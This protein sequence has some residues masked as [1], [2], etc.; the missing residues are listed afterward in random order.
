MSAP[1]ISICIC[2]CRRPA[3]LEQLLAALALQCA[4]DA[5]I[6]VADNDP[7]HS[8]QAVLERWQQRLP[9]R[10]V[11][12]SQPNIALARN[13]TI[14]LAKGHWI[15]LI[16]D[17]ELPSPTWLNDLL[18]TQRRFAA[19]IVMAP[20]LPGYGPEIPAWLREGG[21]FERPRHTT[22]TTITDKDAR[23]GNA[24]IRASLLKAIQ[25]PFDPD[26]G[27]SGGEDSVIFRQLYRSGAQFV[28]CDEAIVTEPVAPDRARPGWL[29]RRAYRFG[30]TTIQVE[31]YRQTLPRQLLIGGY[32][33]AR[34]L[35]QCAIALALS[36]F[37]AP[38]SKIKS[39]RWL[40][41]AVAQLGKLSAL[42]GRRYLEYG[43]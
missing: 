37:N 35:L 8:A 18:D 14:E 13:A 1:G 5:E 32:L 27:R 34:A 21:F 9:L 19:D 41:T 31:L 3:M 16:D 12:V 7:E 4:G 10:F 11:H 42:L 36:I 25:G 30:Q 29:L 38:G 15:A 17:D 28:W 20:V 26:F 43:R 2:T 23:S 39:F 6:L 24:L 40:R 22:G 33:G